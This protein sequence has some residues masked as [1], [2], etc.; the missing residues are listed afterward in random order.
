MMNERAVR[1]DGPVT[2]GKD[3]PA[4]HGDNPDRPAGRGRVLYDAQCPLCSAAIDRFAE[5]LRMRGFARRP[6]SDGDQ[7][8]K[9]GPAEQAEHKPSCECNKPTQVLL[10]LRGGEVLG[11]A[12]A[13]AYL[14]RYFWWAWP[15]WFLWLL[16][17]MRPLMRALY[18]WV[19]AHRHRISAK[20][21]AISAG[22][23]SVF[24]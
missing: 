23:P 1:N 12:Q 24:W 14:A 13:L 22:H 10:E 20:A 8:E 11:G 3:H 4:V 19:A 17:P 16:P 7:V 5:G 2:H 9:A 6:L 21:R 18:G 15:V